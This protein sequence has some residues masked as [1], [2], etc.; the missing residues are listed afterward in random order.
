LLKKEKEFE[1]K[2]G[3]G[4]GEEEKGGRGT[5]EKLISLSE[6]E[7]RGGIKKGGGNQHLVF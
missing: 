1:K 4:G 2:R 7:G 5:Q 3:G 6:P